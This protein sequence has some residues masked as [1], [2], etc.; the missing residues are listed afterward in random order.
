ME[1]LTEKEKEL[2]LEATAQGIDL[3]KMSESIKKFTSKLLNNN[4][5]LK[6]VEYIVKNKHK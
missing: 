2:I 5:L 6:N 4:L 3:Q 1:D